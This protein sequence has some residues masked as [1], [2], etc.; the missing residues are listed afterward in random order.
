MSEAS[1]PPSVSDAPPPLSP[2]AGAR[3]PLRDQLPV[4]SYAV[5]ALVVWTTA[6]SGSLTWN[7]HLQRSAIGDLVLQTARAYFEKDLVY[8]RW[9]AHHGGV[10]VPILQ[11]TPPN[12]YLSGLPDR[13]VVTTTGKRLTLVNPAYMVRQAY[14]I[15]AD[16]AGAQGHLTSLRP[17]RP[18]NAPDGWERSALERLGRGEEELHS[19]EVL[20]GAPHLRFMRRFMVEESCLKCHCSQGYKVGD[21]R[22]GVSI[23]VPL[24]P[25]LAIQ[26]RQM[27]PLASAHGLIW[28]LG[29]AGIVVA[30]RRFG[31]RV[32]EREREERER[33]SLE[34]Q[35]QHAQRIESVGRLTGGIAHDLNNLLSP[36]LGFSSIVLEELPPQDRLRP[37]VEEIKR[38]AQRARELTHR[39]LAFSRKQELKVELLDMAE[40]A[41]GMRKMLGAML[42]EDVELVIAPPCGAP[43]VRADRAQLELVLLNL[44]INARDAM[45]HGGTLRIAV[46]EERLDE[47]SAAIDLPPGRYAA[48]ILSDTGTGMDEQVLNRIFEP[49]FTTK[50]PGKGTGLGLAAV[51]GIVRQHGGTIEVKSSIG[52]GTLLRLLFPAAD[53]PVP[54]APP[55]PGDR[56]P[57]GGERVLVAEDDAAVRK[58][59]CKTLA[60]LGYQVLQADDPR[61]ALRLADGGDQLDL[62]VTDVI[63]PHMNGPEL[64]RRLAGAQPGLAVLFISGNP[65]DALGPSL[66]GPA[67]RPL[68]K[69]FTPSELAHAVRR[70]IDEPKMR[71]PGS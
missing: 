23:S 14:E 43:L 22:G 67:S 4:N 44:A 9:G 38:A 25:Y 13:D 5:L 41:E 45:P 1:G 6:L 50:S 27:L 40:M 8:R 19:T 66:P 2:D 42:G 21:V 10:Y 61:E 15:A 59:V 62:L 53:G 70:A 46:R 7:L 47:R 52:E 71:S 63:M 58:F 37:D 51:H 39:L 24:A 29:V 55:E 54:L 31:Q 35:L 49:F 3:K 34:Q 48:L 30:S 33:R 17:L 69:P 36:I 57:R 16:S 32:K 65:R 60:D 11:D 18:E 28:L 56:L 26:R 64:A 68:W 20:R 12:P